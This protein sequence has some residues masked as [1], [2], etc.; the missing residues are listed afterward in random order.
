MTSIGT[1]GTT[2]TTPTP[3]T[4]DRTVL[5]KDDFLKLLATQLQHQ[6][7]LKPMD[8]MQF[9][10]QMAQFSTL[11]Q[12]TNLRGDL[13]QLTFAGQVG[14]SVALIG[15]TVS[16]VDA[17]GQPAEGV[18]TSVAFADGKITVKV[19]DVDVSPNQIT[20]VR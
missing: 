14:Q 5:G 7:P 6:D 13:D 17:N 15:H 10:G 11:E 4:T 12:I 8:D 2:S 1:V 20:G 19:G 9:I 18:A 3:T 16:Y